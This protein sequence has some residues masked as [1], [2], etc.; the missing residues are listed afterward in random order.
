MVR[1]KERCFE[2]V[3]DK[4]ER[5]LFAL[6]DSAHNIARLVGQ[7]DA[8]GNRIIIAYNQRQ[9]PEHI[10]DSAGRGYLLMFED[11][12]CTVNSGQVRGTARGQGTGQCLQTNTG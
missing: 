11:L 1:T 3:D 7:M 10:E 12:R 5:D 9:L 6:P 4:G 8:N 2:L